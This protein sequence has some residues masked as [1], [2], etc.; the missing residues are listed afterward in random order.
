MRVT[1]KLGSCFIFKETISK[2]SQSL[3]SIKC[4]WLCDSITPVVP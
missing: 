2:G 4:Q 1:R 3:S